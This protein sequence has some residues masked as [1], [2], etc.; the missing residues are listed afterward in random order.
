MSRVRLVFF[1]ALGASFAAA[2]PAGAQ[3]PEQPE[4]VVRTED[5][6]I[7]LA[8]AKRP[9]RT[10]SPRASAP[11]RGRCGSAR[12]GARAGSESAP[13]ACRPSGACTG[14]AR[15]R[16]GKDLK[17]VAGETAALDAYRKPYERFVERLNGSL[18]DP[19]LQAG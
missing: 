5:A 17:E 19:V 15:R 4:D 1:A 11:R 9:P 12:A 7:E 16:F 6:V 10:R 18:D 2:S 8:N 14:A 13:C 3:A